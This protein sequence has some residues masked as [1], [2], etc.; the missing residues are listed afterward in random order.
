MPLTRDADVIVAFSGELSPE[1]MPVPGNDVA[2]ALELAQDVIRQSGR[3]GSVLLIT[4]DLDPADM[5]ILKSNRDKDT[6]P[7]VILA[8]VDQERSPGEAQRLREAANALGSPIEF[9]LPDQRD[10]EA[11]AGKLQHQLSA[12]SGP[13]ATGRWRDAGYFLAPLVAL[14]SIAWFRRGWFLAWEH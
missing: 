2:P 6:A 3:E 9:V 1:L 7:P 12:V 4:D 8:A 13:D 10:V 5:E 14:L 11:V